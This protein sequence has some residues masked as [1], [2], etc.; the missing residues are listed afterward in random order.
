MIK[1]ISVN[2]ILISY[3]AVFVLQEKIKHTEDQS[4]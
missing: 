4:S 3:L 2:F 1:Y